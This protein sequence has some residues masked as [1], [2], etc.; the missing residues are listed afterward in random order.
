MIEFTSKIRNSPPAAVRITYP[1]ECLFLTK[2]EPPKRSA[3]C[4]DTVCCCRKPS[5]RLAFW[6]PQHP[7]Q[8]SNIPSCRIK[9]KGVYN[10]LSR[11][12][13]APRLMMKPPLGGGKYEFVRVLSP[14]RIRTSSHP[15]DQIM[16][17]FMAQMTAALV[18]E[19][20]VTFAVAI[21]KNHVLSSS[22]TAD[23]TIRAVSHALGCPLV[24]LMGESNRRLRGNRQDVVNFVSRI[25]PSRLPW[26][27][28][29]I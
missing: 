6:V 16:E 24:V 7:E 28:W 1:T 11:G 12:V 2:L 25:D 22:A 29:T 15:A 17:A 26:R 20:G 4:R 21:V 27:K 13:G 18:R 19:Q 8:E 23:Q 3:A 9:S 5:S 10:R 14:K